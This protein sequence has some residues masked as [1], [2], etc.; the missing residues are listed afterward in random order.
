MRHIF[1]VHPAITFPVVGDLIR[2]DATP[3][4]I[5]LV[6]EVIPI[7]RT[8]ARVRSVR[9]GNVNGGVFKSLN[10]RRSRWVIFDLELCLRKIFRNAASCWRLVDEYVPADNIAIRQHLAQSL[11]DVDTIWRP[12]NGQDQG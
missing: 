11:K 12:R 8:R 6:L 5:N 9:Y 7:D 1:V 4:H 10:G 3:G 2:S